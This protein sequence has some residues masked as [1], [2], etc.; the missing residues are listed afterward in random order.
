MREWLYERKLQDASLRAAALA[1]ALA[2]EF[3]VRVAAGHINYLLRKVGLSSPPGCPYNTPPRRRRPRAWLTPGFFSLE[4]AKQEMA[5][6]QAVLP[7]LATAATEYQAAQPAAPLRILSSEPATVWH[8]LDHLLYLPVLGLTRPA[9]LY[10]YQGVGLRVVS[11]HDWVRHHYLAPVW[12]HLS[13]YQEVPV[14]FRLRPRPGPAP[15]SCR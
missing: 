5:V 9:D 7:T 13:R 14:P 10:Y 12:Q 6:P 8:K 2:Q 4:A 1:A 15:P 11:L 3:G